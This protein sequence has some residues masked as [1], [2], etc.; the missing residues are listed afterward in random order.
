MPGEVAA[1]LEAAEVVFD[2]QEAEK[3]AR[4][5]A[6]EQ[7]KAAAEAAFAEISAELLAL[8]PA[9]AVIALGDMTFFRWESGVWCDEREEP[10]ADPVY[11]FDDL[12]EAL[13][14]AGP[15]GPPIGAHWPTIA[16]HARGPEPPNP[17]T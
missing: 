7:A 13:E 6:E 16:A 10:D 9:P 5:E 17:S 2:R 15:E 14:W 1:L 8:H 12:D 4:L 11:G 3:A